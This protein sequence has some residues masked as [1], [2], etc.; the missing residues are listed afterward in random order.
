MQPINLTSVKKELV[1]NASQQTAFKVFI[2]QI[3]LWWPRSHHTGSADMTGTVIEQKVNGRWYSTHADNTEADIGYVMQY[4]PYDLLVLAWQLDGDFKCDPTLV[5]E[6]V[7]EFIAE[8]PQTTL[9]KFE[10]QNLHKLN[11][12]KTALSMNEGWGMILNLYKQQ[13]EK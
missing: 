10:H 12:D 7:V 9:V 4:D 5:T 2:E 11:N 13:L 6:V 3:H 1:I 8:G